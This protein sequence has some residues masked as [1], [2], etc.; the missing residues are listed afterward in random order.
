MNVSLEPRAATY[1]DILVISKRAV[2]VTRDLRNCK[3]PQAWHG[4][5]GASFPDQRGQGKRNST[6]S[7]PYRWPWGSSH[8]CSRQTR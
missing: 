2:L 7:R 1:S 8:A 5:D 4:L 6:R 3:M